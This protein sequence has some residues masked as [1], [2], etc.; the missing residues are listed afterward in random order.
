MQAL[1][2]RMTGWG[3]FRQIDDVL[4]ESASHPI[5]PEFTHR[6]ERK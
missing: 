3:H 6:S 2:D 4:D 1:T 5:A